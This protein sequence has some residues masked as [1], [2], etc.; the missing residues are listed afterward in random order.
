MVFHCD[1]CGVRHVDRAEGNCERPW[2]PGLRSR[3]RL[4]TTSWAKKLM[5]VASEVCSVDI[6]R[7]K[8]DVADW[9]VRVESRGGISPPR[10]PRTV[11]EPLDSYGSRCSAVAMT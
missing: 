11:R 9:S 2:A 4:A 5:P 7:P 10:A 8:A 6:S 3:H 1:M